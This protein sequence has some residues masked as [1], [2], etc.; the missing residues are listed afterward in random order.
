MTV[1]KYK[2]KH[3]FPQS[4]EAGFTII[5]SLVAILVAAILLAAIAPAIILATGNRVQARRVELASQAAKAYIDGVSAG[6]IP[7]PTTI[8]ASGKSLNSAPVPT[9][10]EDLYCVDLDS[11][12]GECSKD[13]FKDL[14][15]QGFKTEGEA[16][17]GY[18]LGLR[19]YRAD[20]FKDSETLLKNTDTKKA[21]Q[22]SFGVKLGVNARKAPLVEMT[23]EIVTQETTFKDFCSRLKDGTNKSSGC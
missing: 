11:N 19:V 23:T 3:L 20:A 21:T 7:A 8:V 12:D 18:G 17:T 10:L 6:S 2:I 13:S 15:I 14:L 4:S 16:K 1:S 9:K 5:E 22:S